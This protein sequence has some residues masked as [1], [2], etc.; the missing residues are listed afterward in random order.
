MTHFTIGGRRVGPGEP[1][2]VI[3]EAGSNH[4]GSLDQAL[5]LI[6]AAA[7]AGVDAVKFQAIQY[8]E[9]WVAALE[10]AE[11]RA[12]YT[13]IQLPETWLPQLAAAATAAG[14]HFLCSPTYL[15]S[16]DLI[17]AAGAPGFKLASPQVVG[18]PL[19]LRAVA[20]TGLPSIV[21]TGYADLA[22]IA[23]AVT[24]LERGDAGPFALLHC[25]AEYP[26]P[27]ERMNLRAMQTL[28]DRF[29]KPVGLSDHSP[30]IHLAPAAVAMGASI[31]EKHFTTDRSRSGPDHHFALEPGELAAMVAHIRDVEQAFGEGGRDTN[32]AAERAQ[33]ARLEVRAVAARSIAAGETVSDADV[34]FRRAPGGLSAWTFDG[35]TGTAVR[36]LPAGTPLSAA[37]VRMERR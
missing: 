7:A 20:A 2:Y 28:R 1:C 26:C 3:A 37:D 30:G 18:D 16:V 22:A 32:T 4:D 15:R 21:S 9:L 17:R 12:F 33:I 14:I 27:P 8:D 10:S 35:G 24:T 34:F 25:V 36:D 13:A 5:A 29:N 31:V 11:H 19:I 6:A 23:R